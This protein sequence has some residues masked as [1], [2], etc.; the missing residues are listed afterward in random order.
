VAARRRQFGN[1]RRLPSGRWQARYRGPDGLLRSAPITFATKGDATAFLSMTESELLR[2]S[3]VDPEAGRVPL[4]VFA[5]KW[6]AERPLAP[7]TR[8]KYERLLRLHVEPALGDETLSGITP[9]V[10]RSW[11]S[12]LVADGVGSSTVAQAYRLLRAVMNTAVDDELIRRNPCRVKGADKDEAGERPIAT[13]GQVYEIA[14]LVRP[15]YRALVLTAAFTGLRWGELLALTRADVDLTAGTV[16]VRG[17]VI[18]LDGELS[19]GPAKSRA[20]HRTVAFPMQLAPELKAHLNRYAEAGKSG[21][22]FVG[23]KGAT[24]RRTNFNQTWRKARAAAG[25]PG[26]RFHDLRHTANTFVA[27]QASLGELMRRMGHAST[28]AALIYQHASE[29]RDRAI[30]DA[31]GEL[32]EAWHDERQ[33]DEDEA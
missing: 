18:E 19:L 8:A 33:G 31:L 13:I 6:V 3:W 32:I 27:S 12:S 30:A 16:R 25:L 24:P 11:R 4:G 21:R 20:G 15:W 23:P 29:G 9:A 14:G 26:L 28:R 22:V 1:V 17:A 2:G 5:R 10:V 7:R